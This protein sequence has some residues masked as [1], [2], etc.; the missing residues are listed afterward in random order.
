M[1][2]KEIIL[3]FILFSIPAFGKAEPPTQKRIR[4]AICQLSFTPSTPG[5]QKTIGTG[6]VI[7]PQQVITNFHVIENARSMEDI[8][9]SQPQ[10]DK[11]NPIQIKRTLALDAENDLAVLEVG[12]SV[13]SYLTLGNR[14]PKI[15]EPLFVSGYPEG[16]F[17]EMTNT[18]NI[19]QFKYFDSIPLNY[20]SSLD[21]TSGSP[22]FN[23]QGQIVGVVTTVND[24]FV[25]TVQLRHIQNILNNVNTKPHSNHEKS[26]Q[27]EIQKIIKRAE[28]GH[29][30]AQYMAGH[31][32]LLAGEVTSGLHWL[33]QAAQ[34]G[35]IYA[36][37]QLGTAY[38]KGKYVET[39]ITQN[40][41]QGLRWL[42]TAAQGGHPEAQ[43]TLGSIHYK[44]HSD[45]Q[46]GIHWYKKAAKQGYAQ[47]LY[48]LGI[49]YYAGKGV[50]QD[51][52]TALNYLEK[53]T[54]KGY[55]QAQFTLALINYIT[56]NYKEALDLFEKAAKQGHI[57]AQRYLG[58]MYY[59]GKGVEQNYKEALD[60][61]EKA[62]QQG[63]P[64]AQAI[65]G[66]FYHNGIETT[67]ID[68]ETAK[69]WLKKASE[70]RNF[71]I[72]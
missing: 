41:M 20:Y 7:N 18:G 55:P 51:I 66:V 71:E 19:K 40:K 10:I 31:R 29:P 69:Y 68:D 12:P 58:R 1:N 62:A 15:G 67:E 22:A 59:S 3:L 63:D 35:H 16:E 65:V 45:L 27:E 64:Q 8:T 46:T 24:G 26:V 49:M 30:H 23:K 34:Q 4:S 17:T 11:A 44:T 13:D 6:F 33:Q 39:V 28:Q 54:E 32:L 56:Q 53:A 21:G 38:Y 43:L 47:A 2:I 72:Q 60:W 61:Y 48:V 57:E 42:E 50:V 5:I 14:L 52:K 9:L 70:S 36:Q 37:H 25:Y